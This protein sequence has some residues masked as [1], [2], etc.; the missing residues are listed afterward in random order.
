MKRTP[1]LIILIAVTLAAC[2]YPTTRV[3]I[4]D[5]RPK[6]AI[7]G[8]PDG[9]LLLVDANNMGIAN[10]YNGK[11]NVLIIEPG[12]HKIEIIRND[13]VVYSREVYTGRDTFNKISI[14]TSPLE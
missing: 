13:I 9:A 3:D 8:A 14:G 11:P 5:D 12:R 7:H 10:L 4:I 1:L 2:A 6:I